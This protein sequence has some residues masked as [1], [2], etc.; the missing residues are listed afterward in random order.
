MINYLF[1]VISFVAEWNR[2]DLWTI[3]W[4]IINIFILSV[5]AALA[6][7]RDK[8]LVLVTYIACGVSVLLLVIAGVLTIILSDTLI[9]GAALIAL[10]IYYGYILALYIIYLKL[11]KS[12]PQFIHYITVIIVIV[13]SFAVMVYGFVS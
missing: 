8:G 12:L 3:W 2:T 9:V 6:L 13:T 10:S 1:G 5:Y 11:N 7:L 4:G